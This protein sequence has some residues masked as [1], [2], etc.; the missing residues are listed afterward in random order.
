MFCSFRNWLISAAA[1]VCIIAGSACA[2]EAQ[3]VV[4]YPQELTPD[5]EALAIEAAKR[6]PIAQPRVRPLY[7]E[8]SPP[9]LANRGLPDQAP[10][11]IPSYPPPSSQEDQ[12]GFS[13]PVYSGP[14]PSYGYA[15]PYANW[16]V[17]IYYEPWYARRYRYSSGWVD[18]AYYPHIGHSSRTWSSGAHY[19][20]DYISR[21]YSH[22]GGWSGSSSHSDFH[23]SHGG[24][25]WTAP[26]SRSDFRSSH[27]SAPSVQHFSPHAS[28]I[29]SG[30]RPARA[31]VHTRR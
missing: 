20:D 8:K 24:G 15:A 12:S 2:R 19:H 6:N 21:R 14:A 11:P 28:V 3:A 4:R 10:P 31:V 5:R 27:V 30:G 1:G 26:A 22:A 25:G 9:P 18:H 16:G 23:P 17:G 29:H 13:A 7:P